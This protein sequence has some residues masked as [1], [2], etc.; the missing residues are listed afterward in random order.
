MVSVPQKELLASTPEPPFAKRKKEQSRLFKAPDRK[1]GERQSEREPHIGE[2]E[3]WGLEW[4]HGEERMDSAV[5]ESRFQEYEE[6]KARRSSLG[7]V[8]GSISG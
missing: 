4:E 7:E 1:R 3:R 5:K 8:E 2:R 6:E